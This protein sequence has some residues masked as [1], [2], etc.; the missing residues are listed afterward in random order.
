M[1]D[2]NKGLTTT[3]SSNS[4]MF[5]IEK[6]EQASRLAVSMAKAEVMLPKH[7]HGKPADCMAI[8]IQSVQWGMNPFAVS[9]KT[10][11]VNGTLGYEAQLINAVI[12][13]SKAI[14]GRFKYE[15]NWKDG[16]KDGLVRVGATIR[17]DQHVTWGE[18]LDTRMVTT[19]NSPLWKTAP[20]Q[21]ASY[22]AVKYWARLYTPDVILGVYSVDELQDNPITER[23]INPKPTLA[24]KLDPEQE[25]E[26][27]AEVEEIDDLMLD[28]QNGIDDCSTLEQ[29]EGHARLIA[30]DESLTPLA[31]SKLR[32][33]Y[34]LRQKAIKDGFND[35]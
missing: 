1:S 5:D 29:L 8:I 17:G 21:Q 14:H 28:Y 33:H 31:K 18:W 4:V 9:Q 34:A 7:L 6:M 20:K 30:E 10:H 11:L 27:E 35:E 23:E 2:E 32:G 16:A 22:L 15:Y 12:S 26:V 13:S 25:V 19:K 24:D 3:M